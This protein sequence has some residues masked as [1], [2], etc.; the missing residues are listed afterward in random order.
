MSA[1]I[2]RLRI[3]L[4]LL[5]YLFQLLSCW[6]SL[7]QSDGEMFTLKYF[8][9]DYWLRDFSRRL[10]TI[11]YGDYYIWLFLS[12]WML[13]WEGESWICLA[14]LLYKK[15]THLIV[16]KI[17]FIFYN[18]LGPLENTGIYKAYI[19]GGKQDPQMREVQNMCRK[20]LLKNWEGQRIFQ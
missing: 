6:G 10:E 5:H 7:L 20:G 19:L 16:S 11:I 15:S 14:C 1:L 17:H 13:V 3:M 12:F 9:T 2:T 18:T 8:C 4:P